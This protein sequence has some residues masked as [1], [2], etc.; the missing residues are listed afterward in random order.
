MKDSKDEKEIALD[1]EV[2][3]ILSRLKKPEYPANLD[4]AVMD[5]YRNYIKNKGNKDERTEKDRTGK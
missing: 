5:I 3:K 2:Q 4:R 1:S